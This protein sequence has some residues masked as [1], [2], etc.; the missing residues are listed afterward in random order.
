MLAISCD[1]PGTLTAVDKDMPSRGDGEVLVRVRRIGVC[2]TDLHIFTGNQ[3]YLSYPR[4]MGHE[5]SG[6]MEEAPQGSTLAKGD[7]VTIIPYISCGHCSACLKGK[8]N[9]C[10]NIGVLGVH[11]DG[12]MAEYLSVPQQFVLKAEGLSLD[13]AAMTEFLAIGA[14]AVRRAK[15]EKGQNVLIVGGGPIGMAVAVFAKLDGGRVTVIDGRTDRL[16]F[17]KKHLGVDETVQL[18][19][20]DK[21]RLSEIT[22]GD[23]FDAVFDATGNSKAMERGFSFV[24]HGGTYVLVSIVSSDITFNDPEFHKRETTLLGSRNATIEDFERVIAAQ[25][26]GGVPDALITHRM[27]LTEVPEKFSGL[28]DPAAG[29]VKGMVEVQ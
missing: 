4:I 12:G 13:Q 25:R 18:G 10:R 14:H 26:S 17:C 15:V 6:T 16:D 21:D 27:T 3:P 20:G 19:D 24:G 29:V 28:L 22:G 7:V 1:S 23:F 2:G 9:C 5:L 11:R 8:S